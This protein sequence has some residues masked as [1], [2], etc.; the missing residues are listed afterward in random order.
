MF[1]VNVQPPSYAV[2]VEAAGSSEVSTYLPDRIVPYILEE[3]PLHNYYCENFLY[4]SVKDSSLLT[5]SY[6][7]LHEQNCFNGT[8]IIT[9][10]W[11]VTDNKFQKQLSLI[12][13]IYIP[14]LE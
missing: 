8:E 11:T 10:L 2:A 1:Q 3:R 12:N 5:V 14:F 4:Q 9:V 7:K 6:F 13:F